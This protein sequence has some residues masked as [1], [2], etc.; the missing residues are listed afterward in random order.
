ML[1]GAC[2][3]TGMLKHNLKLFYY[4]SDGKKNGLIFANAIANVYWMNSDFP[5]NFYTVL[6]DFKLRQSGQLR[7]DRMNSFEKIFDSQT[8]K[9]IQ[10][11]YSSFFI[12]QINS[13][14][15]KMSL[16]KYVSLKYDLISM[17]EVGLILGI[18][19]SDVL[20]LVEEGY[21]IPVK[22]T[23]SSNHVFSIQEVHGLLERCIG[24]ITIENH[25]SLISFQEVINRYSVKS[26]TILDIIRY[27]LSGQ[28]TP[29]CI[30]DKKKLADNYYEGKELVLC[31][32]LIKWISKM[33]IG[34]CLAM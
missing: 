19:S 27:T 4:R 17:K 7:C 14:N 9:W 15:I 29:V 21:L 5:K 20:R 10:E 26:L 31:L 8:F 16:Y 28:L 6:Y 32:E 22:V 3:Y 34:M 33:N 2:D 1:D 24:E 11:A 30:G 23:Y 25:H 13:G 18:K 12:D